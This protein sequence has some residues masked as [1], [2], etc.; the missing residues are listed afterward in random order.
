M[1]TNSCPY[2]ASVSRAAR[3]DQWDASLKEHLGECASCC[4]IAQITAWLGDAAR[5]D[6]KKYALPDSDQVWQNAHHLAWQDARKRALRP[7]V[8]AQLIVRIAITL[9]LAAGVIWI[10]F[11]LQSLAA[12]SLTT[13]LNVMKPVIATAIALV[14]CAIPLLF[15]K[16]VQPML[17]ED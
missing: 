13:H 10:W 17:L 4:E 11:R 15:T 8:I 5:S 12:P 2:E 16:L 7:L 6:K 14:I 9:G 3:T 1:N